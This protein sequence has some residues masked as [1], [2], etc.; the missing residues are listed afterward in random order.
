LRGV[1]SGGEPLLIPRPAVRCCASALAGTI[2]SRTDALARTAWRRRQGT[3]LKAGLRG[4]EEAIV[5]GSVRPLSLVRREV[6]GHI[7]EV[8]A[9]LLLLIHPLSRSYHLSIG[10]RQDARPGVLHPE[11]QFVLGNFKAG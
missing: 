6:G 8:T 4:R 9:S 2:H 5:R 7:K 11:I 3:L 10:S 1:A